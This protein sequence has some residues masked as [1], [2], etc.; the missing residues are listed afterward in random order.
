MKTSRVNITSIS[1]S[2]AAKT[3]TQSHTQ[4][5]THTVTHTNTHTCKNNRVIYKQ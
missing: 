4:S 5:H 2:S 3:H 1:D